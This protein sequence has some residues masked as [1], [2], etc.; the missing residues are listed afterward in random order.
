MFKFSHNVL[1]CTKKLHF[2]TK[3]VS[4]T[5]WFFAHTF[6]L[7][8]QFFVNLTWA[9]S[10]GARR[11][12][13]APWKLK[14]D[15]IC[16]RPTKYSTAF[17]LDTLYFSLKRRKITHKFSFAPSARR[18]IV[19][20]LYGAPKTVD[21]LKCPWF[22]PLWKNFCG[23]PWCENFRVFCTERAYDVIIF[24]FQGGGNCPR[25]PPLRAPMDLT[26]YTC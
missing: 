24:K 18:K 1:F 20:F 15:V 17:A 7:L 25:L 23:G 21:F 26:R 10:G 2:G 12:A 8:A 13:L 5:R 6:S 11:G 4:R 14:K 16:C 3:S 19:D 9:P 22:C